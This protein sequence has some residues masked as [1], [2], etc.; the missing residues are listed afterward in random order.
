MSS[1]CEKAL[2]KQ[3]PPPPGVKF[4]RSKRSYPISGTLRNV[5]QIYYN[6]TSDDGSVA[7]LP[8]EEKYLLLFLCAALIG[9]LILFRTRTMI[10]RVLNPFL[11]M[12]PAAPS[13]RMRISAKSVVIEPT[14]DMSEG[15]SQYSTG[16]Q[17]QPSSGLRHRNRADHNLVERLGSEY[18]TSLH[19]WQ[20]ST[21]DAG[22]A[23]L[24][25]TTADAGDAEWQESIADADDTELQETTADTGDTEWQQGT[26]YAREAEWWEFN[27]LSLGHP[28]H[29]S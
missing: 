23:E 10:K 4:D 13:P 12:R 17:N 15:T 20:E 18:Q 9:G 29:L 5:G 24:Q 21:A 25:E 26:A 28:A 6:A 19:P 22:E 27:L 3:L 2:G 1:E 11:Q 7:Y 8:L 14:E 16:L